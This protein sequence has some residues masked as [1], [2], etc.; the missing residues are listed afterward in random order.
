MLMPQQPW[1]QFLPTGKDGELEASETHP[2]AFF[3]TFSLLKLPPAPFFLTHVSSVC[4]NAPSG[5]PPPPPPPPPPLGRVLAYFSPSTPPIEAEQQQE[6]SL[7]V[8]AVAARLQRY[9][10]S[11]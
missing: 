1:Q 6:G 3:T 7:Y 9:V 11:G 10:N 2:E 8:A 5:P 4:C